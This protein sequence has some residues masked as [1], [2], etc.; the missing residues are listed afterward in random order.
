MNAPPAQSVPDRIMIAAA[1][2]PIDRLADLDALRSKIARWV[3]NAVM[4]GVDLVVFPEYGLMEIA[5]TFQDNIAGDLH[6]SLDVVARI[7]PEIEAQLA[8]LAEWHKIHILGPSGPSRRVDGSVANVVQLFAPSGRSGA[9]EKLIVT[10]FERR[11]GVTGGGKPIVFDTRLGRIGVLI[12]Y[13]CEFP[14]LAR[15]M[16]DAGARLILVPS[17]TERISG[18]H[19][20]RTSAMAR[21]LESTVAVVQS[22]TIG[23]AP[24]LPAID[25]NTGAA[26]I[27]VPAEAG[28]SD[29]G[30]VAEGR[31]NELQL[32]IG[33]VDFVR[34]KQLKA[35]GEMRNAADWMLQPGAAAAWTEV[36]VVD[37]TR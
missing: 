27:Y 6:Q 20:V 17:C 31:L 26:G 28:L 14:L 35:E 18:Y 21:A 36:A 3:S 4:Q 2:Y 33:T 19:R 15:A 9:Q 8:E 24:W 23:E 1:Q 34:L 5:G 11:W 32:V 12:C 29:T 16:A 25:R 22:P 30:V 7:R 13:D 37:L 10:P